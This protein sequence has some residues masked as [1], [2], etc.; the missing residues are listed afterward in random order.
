MLGDLRMSRPKKKQKF[1]HIAPVLI[2]SIKRTLGK[3]KCEPIH[4][5]LDSGTTGSIILH[6]YVWKL[7]T[8][9]SQK[10]VEN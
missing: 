4:I 8:R 2:G 1:K 6:Q 3:N 5:L 10:T 9:Q 7:C